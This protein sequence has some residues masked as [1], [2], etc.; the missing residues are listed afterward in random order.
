MSKTINLDKFYTPKKIVDICIEETFKLIK[1]TDIIE[2]SAGNG[3]FS[4]ELEK[5]GYRVTAYDIEP[6]HPSIIKKDYFDISGYKEGRLIIGNPPFGERNNLARKFYNHSTQ[7]G[8][9]I[10][11][12][13]PVSQLN[14]RQSLYKFDLI[15]SMKL[16]KIEYSGIKVHCCFNIYRRPESGLN[17]RE[18]KESKLFKIYR[19]D[20]KDYTNIEADL[21]IGRRG[22]IAGNEVNEEDYSMTYKIVVYDKEN[23]QWIRE[24]ILGYNWKTFKHHHSAPSISQIDIYNIFEE[25]DRRAEIGIVD[26]KQTSLF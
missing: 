8:D 19:N 18:K 7:L 16:P 9:Y 11:F 4:L 23:V 25:K 17:K 10:A 12:I 14:N 5:R 22:T 3:A 6:E 2:P 1:P 15:R 21:C 26:T 13:L 20:Y 24:K